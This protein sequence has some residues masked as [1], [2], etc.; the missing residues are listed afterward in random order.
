LSVEDPVWYQRFLWTLKLE[1]KFISLA[2]AKCSTLDVAGLT[3]NYGPSY[4]IIGGVAVD[5]A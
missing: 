5:E 2:K 1:D 3:F 4:L